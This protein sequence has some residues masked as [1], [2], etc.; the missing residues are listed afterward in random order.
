MPAPLTTVVGHCTDTTA[1]ISISARAG[2]WHGRIAYRAGEVSGSQDVKLSAASPY[3]VGTFQLSGLPAS[4]EVEY[5][6]GV[7]P[8]V[9]GLPPAAQLL[10]SPYFRFRLLP[11]DRPLRIALTS[12]NGGHWVSSD[13][14]RYVLWHR[15]RQEID[16]GRVDLV[17][18]CGDQVYADALREEFARDLRSRALSAARADAMD[19]LRA[20]YRRLYVKA[21]S[22]REVRDVLHAC[23]SIMMWDDHEIYDGWGSSDSDRLPGARAY[24]EA[25]RAA[26]TEFQACNNPPD[27]DPGSFGCGFVLGGLGV[28]MLDARSHRAYWDGVILGEAQWAWIDTWLSRSVGQG[29]RWLYVVAGVPPVHADLGWVLALSELSPGGGSSNLRDWWTAK[30]NLDE[31]HRLLDRLF[32]FERDHGV[33]V[34]IL[35]G[36]VHVGTVGRIRSN[37]PTHATTGHLR[38]VIHQVV[39]SGIASPGPGWVLARLQR[40]LMGNGKVS[41]FRGDIRGDLEPMPGGARFIRDR[42]FAILEADAVSAQTL[43]VRF[44]VEGRSEPLD[45]TLGAD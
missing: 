6:I 42:N 43:H 1:R 7:A 39:S 45:L 9:D 32:A 26:F 27:K 16:A 23:P 37:V 44:F 33:P 10:A 5:A 11:T 17:I 14:R 38:P 34:T 3:N 24:F 15:L 2:R 21:W 25:A 18:H 36:D 12:C 19:H 35:S 20:E 30:N 28:L 13:T 4:R 8:T 22:E 29:M 40:W 41:L 31:C